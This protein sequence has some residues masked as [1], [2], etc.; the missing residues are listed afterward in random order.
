MRPIQRAELEIALPWAA[1]ALGLEPPG[2][3]A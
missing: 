1:E 2:D 3:A